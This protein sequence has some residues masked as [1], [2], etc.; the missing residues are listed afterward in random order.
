[1]IELCF[2]KL[3]LLLSPITKWNL[4]DPLEG[5]IYRCLKQLSIQWNVYF[6][7]LIFSKMNTHTH[8][9]FLIMHTAIIEYLCCW[10]GHTYQWTF[11]F[12]S[13][14][15]PG[16]LL[17]LIF[18]MG[19][20]IYLTSHQNSQ[21]VNYSRVFMPSYCIKLTCFLF[22]IFVYYIAYLTRNRMTVI[23]RRSFDSSFDTLPE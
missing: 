15:I 2:A 22:A 14:A 18:L 6:P 7:Y 23:L 9:F 1:M 8:V 3:L 13:E 4:H 10:S 11:F 20:I 16:I 17:P 12:C 5:N 19:D 21:R